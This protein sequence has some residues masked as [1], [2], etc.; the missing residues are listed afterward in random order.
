[1]S[2][3]GIHCLLTGIAMR[4]T[5]RHKNPTE[6]L[7]TT[8]K[9]VQ[10]NRMDEFTGQKRFNLNPEILAALN[11]LTEDQHISS[12]VLRNKN[13]NFNFFADKIIEIIYLLTF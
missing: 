7:K 9:F 13:V 3:Q 10:M 8:N 12:T 2:E 4:Y 6:K 11:T 5:K 1:M